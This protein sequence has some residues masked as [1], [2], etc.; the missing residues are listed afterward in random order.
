MAAV[1][2]G[3][4]W[5]F[6]GFVFGGLLLLLLF[7]ADSDASPPRWPWALVLVWPAA[8]L[9]FVGVLHAVVPAAG[10][11]LMGKCPEQGRLSP[12]R[13]LLLLPYYALAW[14][15]WALR[16]G[17]LSC[18]RGEALHTE[19][20]DGVHVGRYPVVASWLPDGV[21][22][23]VDLT[24][25]FPGVTREGVEY[26]GCFAFDT[27]TPDPEEWFL[28][29]TTVA[30]RRR[31]GKRVLVH[32]AYGHGRSGVTAALAMLLCP[33]QT[34]V[35]SFEEAAAYLK[36][37]R[38]CIHWYPHQEAAAQ[39]ALQHGAS[40]PL[41]SFDALA[42]GVVIEDAGSDCVKYTGGLRVAD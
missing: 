38:S 18:L 26:I 24:A 41:D 21:D 33:A 9:V 14:V 34:D 35:K 19:V 3:G 36:A 5:V 27:D 12:P 22:V 23:V 7:T 42:T 32:C 29:A 30:A 20:W 37:R 1:V 40:C 39:K 31:E 4:V 15:W 25:E 10:V 11:R 2:L 8:A 28:A 13:V 6:L 17:V 16:V